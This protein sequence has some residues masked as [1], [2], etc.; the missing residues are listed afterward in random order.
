MI[1]RDY[2]RRGPE[3]FGGGSFQRFLPGLTPVVKWI[4]LA[5]L[6]GQALIFLFPQTILEFGGLNTATPWLFPLQVFSY[7]FFHDP[8]NLFHLLLNMLVLYFFGT[9]VEGWLGPKR[10]LRLYLGSGVAGGVFYLAYSL[11]R[12]GGGVCI[13]ASG[14]VSGVLL[15]FCLV[16]PMAEILVL[17]IPV[18]AWIFGAFWVLY[19]VYNML[20]EIR[21]GGGSQV[22]DAAHLGGALMG[23]AFWRYEGLFRRLG[24]SW[25]RKIALERAR[26][27]EED[28]RRMDELLDKVKREGLHSLSEKERRF[29][30]EMSTKLKGRR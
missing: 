29:L 27:L 6:A 10:F 18:R 21:F 24:E 16:Q 12:G 30:Q 17:F 9:T 20:V 7:Q 5:N 1:E 8:L 22:A 15:Y 23:I 14:A 28:R 13:G 25:A 26:R 19:A 3:G 2:M 11:V 4:L